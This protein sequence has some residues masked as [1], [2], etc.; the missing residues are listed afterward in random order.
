MQQVE[1]WEQILHLSVQ[2]HRAA[3]PA[4]APTSGYREF[5]QAVKQNATQ[6]PGEPCFRPSGDTGYKAF[7]SLLSTGGACTHTA[8]PGTDGEHGG[9]KPFQ[10]SG[11]NQCPGSMPLFTFGLDM[12]LPPSPLNSAPPNS[13][14]E[15]FDLKLGLKGADRPK[16]PPSTDQVT[17]PLGDDLGL[18]IVYSS[19][20]CHLCGHLKQHH[21]QEEGSQTH[22]VASPCC[23]CCYDERSPS[24]GSL[25]G[26]LESCPGEM[27]PEASLPSAARTP[28]NLS[29]QGKTP[30]RS[31]SSQTTEAPAATPCTAVS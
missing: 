15:C 26:A 7:S 8:E 6:D 27:P 5:A 4:P 28:L 11:P 21:S 16:A 2:Q 24:L 10:N 1:S 22:V 18:G 25:L 9:Y 20:T 23:G 12:E 13:T 17:K 30:G 29:G 14:P 19:V 31:V 3:G